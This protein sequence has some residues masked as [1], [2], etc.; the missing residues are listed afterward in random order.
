MST[1]VGLL[2]MRKGQRDYCAGCIEKSHCC[3]RHS[4]RFERLDVGQ[5]FVKDLDTG[6][7][8]DFLRQTTMLSLSAR[9]LHCYAAT[10]RPSARQD[11]SKTLYL[12]LV[13]LR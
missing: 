2:K 12:L 8:T 7:T 9:S 10:T 11:L 6:S 13:A 4:S 5:A 1:D 3:R